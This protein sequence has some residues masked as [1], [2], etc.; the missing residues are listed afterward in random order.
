MQA[1]EASPERPYGDP[2][3]ELARHFAA[4]LFLRAYLDFPSFGLKENEAYRKVHLWH[5]KPF[6]RLVAIGR[7][8][9][10]WWI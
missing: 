6:A 1:F 10:G 2:T 4:M 9:G 7:R 8:L 5:R 3:R